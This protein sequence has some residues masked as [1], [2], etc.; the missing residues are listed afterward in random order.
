MARD[1]TRAPSGVPAPGAP[2]VNGA[3]P[4]VN[5]HRHNEPVRRAAR[6]TERI[7][8]APWRDGLLWLTLLLTLFAVAPF[9][10][11]GY[12]WGANDARH[13]VY[14]L[15]EFNR[16]VE[17]GVWWPR[18]SPDFAFGYG[19]PFFNI[20]GPLSHL[21][22]T[23][24]LRAFSLSYTD[25]VEAVFVLGIVASAATMYL[26]VRSWW[27]RAAGLVAALVYTYAPYHLLNLYVRANLAESSAFVWLP[28]IL[29]STREAVR[30]D[31]WRARAPW[32]LLLAFSY[33]AL[34]I[35]SNLVIVLLSVGL[36]PFYGLAL[37]VAHHSP[38]GTMDLTLPPAVR[39]RLNAWAFTRRA[40]APALGALGGIGLSAFF[41]LP[42]FLERQYVLQE[43][44]FDGR[45]NFRGHFIYLFQL[46]S[47]R[48]GFGV[49]EVGP[50]D[51]IGF[52]LGTVPLVLAAAGVL[53]AWR[54]LGRDRWTVGALIVGALATTFAALTWAAPLWEAPIVGGVLGAAQFPWRWLLVPTLCLSV[55]AGLVARDVG[56]RP[57]A[58]QRATPLA[59]LLLAALIVLGSYDRL[60]VE[61]IEPP[62]GPVGLPALMRFQRTSDEMTGSTAYVN[63]VPIWSEMATE[64]LRREAESP[65]QPV[66]PL[67]SKL[68]NSDA[69]MDYTAQTGHVAASVSH[70]TLHEEVWYFSGRDDWSIVFNHFYYPGWRAYLLDGEGGDPVRELPVV[71]ESDPDAVPGGRMTVPV[72]R[73]EGY[74]LLRFEPTPIRTL[75]RWVSIASLVVLLSA[76]AV[77]R[78]WPLQQLPVGDRNV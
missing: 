68:D 31:R 2:R 76:A 15:F 50:N 46:F 60:R 70:S 71:P 49:S 11:P 30:V 56:E 57:A 41:A 25:A 36:L 42:A 14:F 5:G 47:P 48:W 54:T 63:Q 4:G 64:Y 73:G 28:L 55:L 77:A 67:E 20:Y 74:V 61:I 8:P 29:W 66:L 32:V 38:S 51:A 43:Q 37:L 9:A 53:L 7:L 10:Q 24:L 6:T 72:P 27:G 16:V 34:M 39:A 12:H 22:G 35:T 17:D 26:F 78:F 40:I 58:A 75:S 23:V 59:V 3:V 19:Y 69:Q 45:Y 13:H 33:A 52:G 65:D 62:E 1:N 21:V 44:W 18:W